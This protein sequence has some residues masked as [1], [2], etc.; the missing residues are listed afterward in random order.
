MLENLKRGDVVYTDVLS[1][2]RSGMSRTIRVLICA[3]NKI[4]DVSFET[5]KILD[6]PLAKNGGVR[7]GGCGM[8]MCFKIVYLLGKSLL[9]DGYAFKNEQF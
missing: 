3:D 1:V 2:A 5:A 4:H 7:I 8:D 6:L 9:K